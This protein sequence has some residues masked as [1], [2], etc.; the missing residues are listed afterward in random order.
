MPWTIDVCG[1]CGRLAV[2][3]GC[4]HWQSKP[5]WCVPVRVHPADA[6]GRRLDA[7]QGAAVAALNKLGAE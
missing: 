5:G 7:L 6:E 4:E 1:T 3:P 2:W